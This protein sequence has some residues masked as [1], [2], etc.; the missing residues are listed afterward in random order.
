[1]VLLTIIGSSSEH[2]IYVDQPI[3]KPN[4]IR[5]LSCTFYNSWHNLKKEFEI[6]VAKTGMEDK[7]TIVNIK[8][9]YYTPKSLAKTITGKFAERGV[10]FFCERLYSSRGP[11]VFEPKSKTINL[12]T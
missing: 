2:T 1:M 8:P 4:Y 7:R 5:L 12:F 3:K 10:K 9:G 11:G 6:S